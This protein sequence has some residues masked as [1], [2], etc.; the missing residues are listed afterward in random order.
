MTLLLDKEF[1]AAYFFAFST[2][3][4]SYH[5]F[6]ACQISVYMSATKLMCLPLYVNGLLSLDAFR[7]L[8]LSLYFISFTM[9]CHGVDLFL[10]SF[11]GI[12]LCL[13]DLNACFLPRLGKFSAIICTKKPSSPFFCSYS[14]GITMIG[15][16][17]CFMESVL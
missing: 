5:S 12:S 7:V 17:F 11:E 4:I 8:S 3:N 10:L 2:L 16:V 15:I 13:L 6:P 1:L 9:I 14:S